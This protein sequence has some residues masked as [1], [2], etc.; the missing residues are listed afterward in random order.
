[1]KAFLRMSLLGLALLAL[2]GCGQRGLS[3]EEYHDTVISVLKSD[4][5][6]PEAPSEDS[7]FASM[8]SVLLNDLGC[9]GQ[10]CL[11]PLRFE[12]LR[13]SARSNR[14]QLANFRGQLCDKKLQPPAQE[15]EAHQKICAGLL[16]I[17][18]EV[19]AIETTS[20]MALKL[21]PRTPGAPLEPAVQI[22]LE[23]AAAN[24]AR[25]QQKIRDI[26]TSLQ[27]IPWL[28]RTLPRLP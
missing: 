28:T 10:A 12:H 19:G 21:F 11:L 9:I 1:M 24:L 7:G 20:E 5:S 16:Q 22:A 14:S 26:V 13:D 4:P 8:I 23:G 18:Q 17:F 15:E 6:Q 27:Q 25:S 3:V 2:A